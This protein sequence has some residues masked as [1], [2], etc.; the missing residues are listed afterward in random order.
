MLA[1][2]RV[3]RTRA[4]QR[5]RGLLAVVIDEHAVAAVEHALGDGVEQLEGRHDGAGGQH[6]DL[7]IAA[8][9]IVDL[10]G[11]VVGVLVEDILRGPGA[12]PAHAD[13]ALRLDDGRRGNRSGDSPHAAPFRNL[14]RVEMD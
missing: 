11:E 7:E 12:L 5:Q 1:S 10:L 4:P 9:H 2:M 6:F 13:G 14:R 8:G 3:A